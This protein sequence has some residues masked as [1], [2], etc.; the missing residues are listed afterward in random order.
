MTKLSRRQILVEDVDR[1]GPQGIYCKNV[2]M[3]VCSKGRAALQGQSRQA[4]QD[5]AG[6]LSTESRSG[7]ETEVT[8]VQVSSQGWV[9]LLPS[10]LSKREQR[11]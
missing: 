7:A 5:I 1:L 6:V 2:S 9:F 4:F 10:R 8:S 11:G 3:P